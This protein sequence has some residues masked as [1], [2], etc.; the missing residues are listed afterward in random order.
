MN[1]DQFTERLAVTFLGLLAFCT[2]AG[3]IVLAWNDKSLP[4]EI[5]AIGSAAAG[6]IG[7][8]FSNLGRGSDPTPV[9]VVNAPADAIP[10]TDVPNPATPKKRVR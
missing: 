3:G 7:G 5:I 9:N 8:M 1:N 6:V 10:T 2:V 4:G